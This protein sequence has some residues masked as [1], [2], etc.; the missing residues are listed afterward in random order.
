MMGSVAPLNVGT[1]LAASDS[2]R[3]L[4]TAPYYA[5]VGRKPHPVT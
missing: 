2:V 1:P 3:S 4:A 5:T